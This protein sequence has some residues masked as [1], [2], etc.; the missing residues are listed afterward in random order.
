MPALT[1]FGEKAKAATGDDQAFRAIQA[2]VLAY[3][4]GSLTEIPFY[5]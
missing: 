1:I 5:A 4:T 3:L 2:D